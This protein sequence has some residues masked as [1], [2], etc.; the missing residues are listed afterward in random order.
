MTGE[1]TRISSYGGLEDVI[2]EAADA[3]WLG[4][5]IWRLLTGALRPAPA[6][7]LTARGAATT[8]K[9]RDVW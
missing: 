4:D 7:V 3:G 6:S 5:Q 2:H 9:S 1:A 8:L